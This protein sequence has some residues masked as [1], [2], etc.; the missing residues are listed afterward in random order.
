MAQNEI[1]NTVLKS[2][3]NSASNTVH[4]SAV[5]FDLDSTLF[6][7]SPR[8]QAIVHSFCS[9]AEFK[10]R[11]KDEIEILK[12]VELQPTDWGLRSALERHKQPINPELF[13]ALRKYWGRCFFS[14]QFMHHDTMYPEASTYV[15]RL[16]DAGAQIFYLTGR[17]AHS[18]YEGTVRNLELHQFPFDPEGMLFMK[19]SDHDSDED[20]KTTWFRHNVARFNQI[21]F[22]ENEPVIIEQV[23]AAV[24]SVKIVFMDSTHSGRALKPVDLPAIGMDYK[25]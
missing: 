25:I 1:L 14:N 11:F 2:V 10:E 19:P 18:M 16:Q 22:F 4:P 13:A 24:P 21:W 17:H 5:V 6:C 7:V 9:K 8:T 20:F 3:E 15:R 12:E 23:R